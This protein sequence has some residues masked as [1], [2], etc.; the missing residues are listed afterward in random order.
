[1]MIHNQ[2]LIEQNNN[3]LIRTMLQKGHKDGN[4]VMIIMKIV[5]LIIGI[6]IVSVNQVLIAIRANPVV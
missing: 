5:T 6:K 3:V 4:I 2:C 1:M